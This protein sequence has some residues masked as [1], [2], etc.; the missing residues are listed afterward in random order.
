[1]DVRFSLSDRDK[2]KQNYAHCHNS[3]LG[4]K[5]A[6]FKGGR[7]LPKFRNAFPSSFDEMAQFDL[8]AMVDKALSISGRDHLH[9]VGYSQ[10]LDIV[11]LARTAGL[12]RAGR[13]EGKDTVG[14]S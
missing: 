5:W 13:G 3:M 7:S 6:G 9:Y 14:Y 1:M 11:A 4:A 10:V 2:E 8:E 12:E